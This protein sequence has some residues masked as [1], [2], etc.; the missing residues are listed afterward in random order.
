MAA[1]IAGKRASYRIGIK[2][3]GQCGFL[4]I[5]LGGYSLGG[6]KLGKPA[7]TLSHHIYDILTN[8]RMLV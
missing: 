3:S 6:R 8:L 4:F 7:R 5:R 2:K 1:K